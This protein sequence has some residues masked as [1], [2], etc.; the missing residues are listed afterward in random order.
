MTGI[1]DFVQQTH[2]F[3]SIGAKLS[4]AEGAIARIPLLADRH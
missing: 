2:N 4:Q 3:I 1:S